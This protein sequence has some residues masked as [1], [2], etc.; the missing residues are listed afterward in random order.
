M[1]SIF[2][3]VIRTLVK[4][5]HFTGGSNIDNAP[6]DTPDR[7][8]LSQVLRDF[9]DDLVNVQL[10]KLVAAAVAAPAAVTVVG[11]VAAPAAVTAAG[12]I[13][14]ASNPPTQAEVN[15]LISDHNNAVSDIAALR[16]TIASLVTDHNKAATDVTALRGTVNN[17][18]T[19]ANEVRTNVNAAGRTATAA[20][21]VSNNAQAYNLSSADGYT[22][23][24]ELAGFALSVP[25]S[26]SNIAQYAANPA[27]VTAAE[28]VDILEASGLRRRGVV[29]SVSGGTKVALT[30]ERKGVSVTLNTFAGTLETALDFTGGVTTAGTGYE[31]IVGKA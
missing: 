12:A 21:V 20:I 1:K 25:V 18:V 6:A 16:A 11:A 27:A 26:A 15:A 17:A 9:A 3:H 31:P 23:T 4:R 2:G 13:G 29:P 8:V 10:P 5:A 28:L 14:A 22:F 30:T 19:L 7:P 24:F